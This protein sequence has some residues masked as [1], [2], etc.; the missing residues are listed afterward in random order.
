[1]SKRYDCVVA[2]DQYNDK[3]GQ[4]KTKWLNV[5]VIL[6]TQ[7]GGLVMKLDA[8]PITVVDKHGERAPFEGWIK[9]FEPRQQSSQKPAPT[10]E[11][12]QPPVEPD[13]GFD[14]IPF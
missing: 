11:R 8:M 13:G 9:L 12:P 2:V 3:E 6:E 1:M 4:T 7:G 10:G 14:D 5:G